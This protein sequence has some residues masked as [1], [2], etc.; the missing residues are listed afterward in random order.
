MRYFILINW[1]LVMTGCFMPWLYPKLFVIGMDG[2]DMVDGKVI[3]A[4][5]IVGIVVSMVQ[6]RVQRKGLFMLQGL[7]GLGIIAISGM[8]LLVFYQRAYPV[9]PGLFLVFLC[10][11]QIVCAVTSAYRRPLL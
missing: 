10:A 5:A 6:F 2:I 8:E 1:I 7:L 11:T 3:L 9:G 4:L